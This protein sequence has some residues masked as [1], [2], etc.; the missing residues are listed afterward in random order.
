MGDLSG[1]W[2]SAE[3]VWRRGERPRRRE[4]DL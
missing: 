1:F 2:R 3:V 4:V